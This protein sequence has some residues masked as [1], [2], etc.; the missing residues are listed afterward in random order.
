[1]KKIQI[2]NKKRF[3]V[4]VIGIVLIVFALSFGI[5]KTVKWYKQTPAIEKMSIKEAA[6]SG[7]KKTVQLL[8][9]I[10]DT[11]GVEGTL[12]RG[13]VLFT[14]D[15]NKEFS[16]AE[17]EGFLI[18]KMRLTEEQQQL[19]ELSLKEKAGV[20]AN[21]QEQ[22]NPKEIKRRKFAVD[23]AKIGI[24][25]DETRGKVVTDKVFEDDVLVQK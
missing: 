11:G 1:M 7:E 15:E 3:A 2:E 22:Q 6:K 19:L 10:Y 21:E 24:A 17:Q 16:T 14:A 25:S 20:F 5:Y 9:Q 8:I 23:L 4:F 12:Q 13:D 18:I